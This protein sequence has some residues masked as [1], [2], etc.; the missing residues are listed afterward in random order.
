MTVTLH[1]RC[2]IFTYL[3]MYGSSH[4]PPRR[5]TRPSAHMYLK[6]YLLGLLRVYRPRSKPGTGM[7]G[8]L[9]SKL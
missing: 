7:G 4:Y 8:T 9:T 6:G 5:Q 1:T 3:L 2:T